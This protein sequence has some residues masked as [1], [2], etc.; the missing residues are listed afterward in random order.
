MNSIQELVCQSETYVQISELVQTGN[1][2]MVSQTKE[3]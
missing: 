3:S 2:F 1:K